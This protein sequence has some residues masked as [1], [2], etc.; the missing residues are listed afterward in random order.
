MTTRLYRQLLHGVSI[1]LMLHSTGLYAGW[2]EVMPESRQ[3]GEGQFRVY[4]FS[5]YSATLWSTGAMSGDFRDFQSPFALELAYK[6]AISRDDLVSAS[7][8]EMRRLAITGQSPEVL[9]HW[10]REMTLAFMDVRAGDRITGLYLPGE[11]THFYIGAELR[12]VVKGEAF[13]RAF[14]AIWLDSR[15]RDPELRAQLLGIAKP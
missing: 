7:I 5:I 10:R 12:H 2:R 6:R 3:V 15:T 9:A 13:A 4:G 11:G 8:K 1:A 14:F